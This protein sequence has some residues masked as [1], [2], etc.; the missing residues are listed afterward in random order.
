MKT[1]IINIKAS[2]EV[3]DDFD[4]NNISLCENYFDKLTGQE[5]FVPKS[6]DFR[7]IDYIDI[8]EEVE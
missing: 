4:I 2:I 5:F 6:Q 3:S 8:I 7:V 1:M